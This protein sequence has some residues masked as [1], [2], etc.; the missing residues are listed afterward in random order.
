MRTPPVGTLSAVWW[1]APL[2]CS[3]PMDTLPTKSVGVR[4]RQA[5]AMPKFWYSLL[6]TYKK[7]KSFP[8]RWSCGGIHLS[9]PL[10]QK[11]ALVVGRNVP[12]LRTPPM[13][14]LPTKSVG[15]RLRQA[16]AMPTFCDSLIPTYKTAHFARNVKKKR[17]TQTVN[18][19]GWGQRSRT[20]T[21]RFRVCCPAIRRAPTNEC[22]YY[23]IPAF[24]YKGSSRNSLSWLRILMFSTSP[25]PSSIETSELPP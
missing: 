8:V 23:H 6:P 20:S 5:H 12:L 7:F 18:L 10:C 24:S 16:L 22:Q 25:I 14:T 2:L 9:S 19:S 21:Y 3:P 17:L 15:V 4:L 11:N 13:D 1:N